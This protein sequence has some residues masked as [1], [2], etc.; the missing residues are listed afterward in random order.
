MAK[1]AS[2]PA[3]KLGS[4]HFA[5]WLT[6][7]KD[8]RATLWGAAGSMAMPMSEFARQAVQE[9]VRRVEAGQKP[10]PEAK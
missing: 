4:D 5:V 10:F 8:F 1:K 2:K 9:A 3:S 6:F 7:P